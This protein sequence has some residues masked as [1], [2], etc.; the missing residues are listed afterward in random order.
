MVS[1][2]ATLVGG[3]YWPSTISGLSGFGRGAVPDDDDEVDD[4]DEEDD[5]VD[6][7]AAEAEAEA[8]AGADK[9][10]AAPTEAGG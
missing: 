8:D 6:E 1:A 4:D 2:P 7:V 10:E 3:T 9:V 5:D